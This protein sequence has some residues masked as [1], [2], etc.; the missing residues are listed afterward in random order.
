[1]RIK[2]FSRVLK[3]GTLRRRGGEQQRLRRASQGEP[4]PF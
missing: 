4:S 2:E 1:M 3:G